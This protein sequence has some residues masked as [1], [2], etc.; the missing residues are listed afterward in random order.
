MST[1]LKKSY[2]TL[3]WG[4]KFLFFCC[5]KIFFEDFSKEIG[6]CEGLIGIITFLQLGQFIQNLLVFVAVLVRCI[7]ERMKVTAHWMKNLENTLYYLYPIGL[8]LY[9]IY[10]SDLFK[11]LRCPFSRL[12]FSTHAVYKYLQWSVSLSSN[13][14]LSVSLSPLTTYSPLLPSTIIQKYIDDF[15]KQYYCI[16]KKFYRILLWCFCHHGPLLKKV[17]TMIIYLHSMVVTR[18]IYLYNTECQYYPGNVV[19]YHCQKFYNT[20]PRNW[21]YKTFF[22]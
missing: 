20:G 8:T 19:N 17:V 11:I 10:L 14:F 16:E 13:L 22:P 7:V 1:A 21:S 15:H 18:V 12:L 6:F 9:L 5:L 3:T 4:T 2:T